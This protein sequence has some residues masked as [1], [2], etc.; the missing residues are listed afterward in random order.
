MLQIEVS[1][2]IHPWQNKVLNQIIVDLFSCYLMVLHRE[3]FSN[4]KLHHYSLLT[5]LLFI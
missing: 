4:A 2:E 1:F 3:D 5:F